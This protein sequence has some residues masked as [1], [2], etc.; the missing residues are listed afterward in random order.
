MQPAAPPA[1]VHAAHHALNQALKATQGPPSVG[2]KPMP[3]Q[4]PGQPVGPGGMGGKPA[5][6]AQQ[7]G[8]NPE[9]CGGLGWYDASSS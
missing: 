7:R 9:P 1:A 4:H 8:M 6:M 2:G 3:G 5:A